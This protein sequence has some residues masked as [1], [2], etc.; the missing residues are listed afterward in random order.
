MQNHKLVHSTMRGEIRN[1]KWREMFAKPL[2]S[3]PNSNSR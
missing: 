2:G 1:E 3:D